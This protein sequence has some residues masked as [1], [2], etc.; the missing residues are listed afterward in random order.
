VISSPVKRKELERNRRVEPLFISKGKGGKFRK[1]PKDS[2]ARREQGKEG[3][4]IFA[5]KKGSA[6]SLEKQD[7]EDLLSLRKRKAPGWGGPLI[8]IEEG[9]TLLE[10]L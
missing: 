9:V 2:F 4:L 1:R 10:I 3:R 6:I 5:K 7:N 8:L